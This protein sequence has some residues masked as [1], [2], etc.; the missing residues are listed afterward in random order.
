MY[1]FPSP[2]PATMRDHRSVLIPASLKGRTM[3]LAI[4]HSRIKPSLIWVV[5]TLLGIFFALK[6]QLL[7]DRVIGYR[8]PLYT[9]F[10]LQMT[11]AYIY[12]PATLVVLRLG[13]LFPVDRSNWIRRIPLHF[14]FCVIFAVIIESLSVATT[15]F[16]LHP[17]GIRAVSVDM[18]YAA[19]LTN[20]LDTQIYIYWAIIFIGA[21]L[22]YY[23]RYQK[24]ELHTSR[25]ETQLA[26]AELQILK[27]QLHPHFLFNTL[28]SIAT[29]IREQPDTADRMVAY[30]GDFLR[31]T[32][33]DSGLEEVPLRR[34]LEILNSYLQIESMRFQDRL[35][36]E[37][38]VAPETL[39]AQVPSLILQPLVENSIKHGIAPY[40]SAGHIEIHAFREAGMLR[41]IVNDDG[42]GLASDE[43]I[44]FGL[45]LSNTYAR[46][47]HLY[48]DS[49]QFEVRNSSPSGFTAEIAIPFRHSQ[50]EQSN[51]KN[52]DVDR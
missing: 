11:Q 7:S 23:Q 40:A 4:E 13:R 35:H 22:G 10:L 2:K 15:A 49:F 28:N 34:E 20:G 27:S 44:K 42:P 46:L 33:K 37:T 17:N 16:Y 18:I 38:D 41:I 9:A 39:D 47:E 3:A 5:W 50:L 14:I 32:L 29:L 21:A 24:E 51:G 12:F 52:Q 48:G 36:V 6:V 30:L 19:L 26:R 45:G 31:A 25:L 43:P 8:I 1:D